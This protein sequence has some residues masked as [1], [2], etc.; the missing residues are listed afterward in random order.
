M[1]PNCRHIAEFLRRTRVLLMPS[2]WYEGFGLIVMEAM[3][4]G[5]PVVS[6]DAGG[7]VEAKHGNAGYVMP[8]R[9]IERYRPEFDEHSHAAAGNRPDSTSGPWVAGAA[10]VARRDR[11]PTSANRQ[12][13]ARRRWLRRT[14]WMPG[15]WSD[16]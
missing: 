7:L 6:S 8:V 3:L 14:A 2:L 10:R 5:I 12:P 15:A 1:L 9:A 11:E 13:P 4:R 16:F